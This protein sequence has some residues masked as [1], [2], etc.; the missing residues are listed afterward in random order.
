VK[1]LFNLSQYE[2]LV[3]A[4]FEK[5]YEF[6]DFE[7]ARRRFGEGLDHFSVWRHDI[8]FCLQ[9]ALEMARVESD[10]G[11][12]A[13]YHV[14][15]RSPMYNLLEPRKIE[16]LHKLMDL[17]H[18]MG[19][20][21]DASLY[22]DS[23]DASLGERIEEECETLESWLGSR[24]KMVSYHRPTEDLYQRNITL[25]DRSHVHEPVF[26]NDLVYFSDSGGQWRRGFP[27]ESSAFASGRP[28]QIVTHPI[29]WT[30]KAGETPTER[31]NA[32][33]AGFLDDLG[34]EIAAN[35]LTYNLKDVKRL[36]DGQEDSL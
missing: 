21:F 32:F 12:R 15:L 23:D 26:F 7:E 27:L 35:C 34:R 2:E 4:F 30:G 24:V 9:R 11:I 17:R 1:P 31:L 20:H 19:L 10:L 8:D 3:K 6:V 25:E 36:P 18:G 5:G 16:M 22:E 29:W 33:A 28:I 14:L 13:D